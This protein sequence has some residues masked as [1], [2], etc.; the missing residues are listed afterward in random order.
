[1]VVDRGELHRVAVVGQNAT[2]LQEVPLFSSLEPVNNILLHQVGHIHFPHL[3]QTNPCY[4]DTLFLLISNSLSPGSGS[5]GQPSVSGSSPSWRLRSVYQLRR[6]CQSQ[7]PGLWV[8]RRYLQ[9]FYSR[10]STK[11]ISNEKEGKGGL[12]DHRDRKWCSSVLKKNRDSFYGKVITYGCIFKWSRT[13]LNTS[14]YEN[15]S[16]IWQLTCISDSC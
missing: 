8:D 11:G 2:L 5:G 13:L 12:L 1:M 7:R 6:V 9:A 14:H 3:L 15:L 4:T 10:V 16:F